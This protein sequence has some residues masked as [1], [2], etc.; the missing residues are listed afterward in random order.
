[1]TGKRR[2]DEADVQG[3]ADH[4]A[5]TIVSAIRIFT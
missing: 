2:A 3:K 5:T 1:M 4:Q